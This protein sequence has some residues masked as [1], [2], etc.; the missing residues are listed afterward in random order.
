VRCTL[1][2]DDPWSGRTPIPDGIERIRAKVDCEPYQYGSVM[3]Q[4]LDL[5]KTYVSEFLKKVL[6]LKNIHYVGFRT[7]ST[8]IKQLSE[9][10]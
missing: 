9:L 4:D 5:S 2:A 8:T 10:K 6:K 7:L 1:L 3:A